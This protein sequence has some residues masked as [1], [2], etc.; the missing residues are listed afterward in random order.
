MM[1]KSATIGKI[2]RDGARQS[3]TTSIVTLKDEPHCVQISI[4]D[5]SARRPDG[6]RHVLRQ[7]DRV[8]YTLTE[9]LQQIKLLK[10]AA[11]IFQTIDDP[12]EGVK[13][14]SGRR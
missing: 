1:R 14:K 3:V 7:R 9:T 6:S 12:V 11:D 8:Q 2:E 13:K 10:K 5:L 4:E